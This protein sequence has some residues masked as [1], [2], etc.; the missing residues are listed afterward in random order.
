[1]PIV[2]KATLKSYFNN[3]DNPT[4]SEYVDLIDS[5]GT[6]D[7]LKS[8]YD[9]DADG[10]VTP[11]DHNTTHQLTG[12]DPIK[13]DDLAA[14]DNNTDLDVSISKHGLTPKAPDDTSKF[15]R[16]DAAWAA[17]VVPKLD[18]LSAPDDNTDLDVSISKHG[19]TPRAPN[20]VT[21]FLR[22][23]AAWA[24]IDWFA[25]TATWTYV[26]ASSFII[27]GN[28]TTKFPIGTKLK[29]TNSTVK[30]FYVVSATYGAPNTTI[31]VTGG[32][33]YTLVNS[34]IT[35]TFYSYTD[36][37]QGFPNAFAYTPVWAASGTQPAIGNG[38]LLGYFSISGRVMIISISQTMGSSTTYGTGT[39][40]WSLPVSPW[41]ICTG[42]AQA[43]DAGTAFHIGTI[44]AL[45][46]N[47]I[48]VV[49][50]GAANIWGQLLPHTW[51][52]NDYFRFSLISIF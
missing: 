32:S 6:G 15:L 10:K 11:E 29:L 45:A 21:K 39:Y 49:S 41:L 4:Y 47:T 13:L 26:S 31:T 5:L 28:V 27:T 24:T 44:H 18:D 34:A 38:S 19:L 46:A 51:A 30:Y 8:D 3:A 25:D 1:M 14:P 35:D 2:D 12:G 43:L 20:D 16:G 33:A 37:P 17:P 48:G 50:E 42:G 40:S 9:A 23:D 22:G 36:S 7:M 52:V